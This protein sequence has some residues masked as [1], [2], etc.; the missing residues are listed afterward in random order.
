MRMSLD[1]VDLLQLQEIWSRRPIITAFTRL[2]T[3][4]TLRPST[5]NFRVED[6]IPRLA[7]LKRS[8]AWLSRRNSPTLSDPARIPLGDF[9]DD[10]LLEL[11]PEVESPA[12]KRYSLFL[13]VYNCYLV[14]HYERPV[15]HTAAALQLLARVRRFEAFAGLDSAHLPAQGSPEWIPLN[16][17]DE[18]R[19]LDDRYDPAEPGAPATYVVADEFWPLLLKA[20]PEDVDSVTQLALESSE[21]DFCRGLHDV[22]NELMILAHIWYRSPSVVGLAYQQK[23]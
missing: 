15:I 3:R 18:I 22:L 10:Y 4:S 21:P 20:T 6:L 16:I 5:D 17:T 23:E 8:A 9:S 11:Y 13:S 1:A 19:S 7:R 12:A 14:A 2:E